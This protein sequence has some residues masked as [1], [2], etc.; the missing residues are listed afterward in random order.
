MIEN[1]MT[2]ICL[3]VFAV[4]LALTII[5]ILRWLNV[6]VNDRKK[7]L[8]VVGI[9]ASITLSLMILTLNWGRV[10]NVWNQF[11]GMVGS[12]EQATTGLITTCK[13]T[14]KV[15]LIGTIAAFAIL[16]ALAALLFILYGIY[17][18]FFTAFSFFCNNDGKKLQDDLKTKSNKIINMFNNPIFILIITGGILAVFCIIPLI[19]GIDSGSVAECWSQGIGIIGKFVG[20]KKGTFYEY[21]SLY[22][23]VFISVIGIGFAACHIIYEIIKKEFKSEEK[24]SF[25][26]EYSNSIGLITVGISLLV[27]IT[28]E[29]FTPPGSGNWLKFFGNALISFGSVI[30]IVALGIICL[31]TIRLLI[32]MKEDLIRR[33]AR[34]VFILV[35]GHCTVVLIRTL[36]MLYNVAISILKGK[37]SRDGDCKDAMDDIQEKITNYVIK[38]LD[39][40]IRNPNK[41]R[42]EQKLTIPYH[43]FKEQIT[44]K[45]VGDKLYE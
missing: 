1:M 29:K 33:G 43:F 36:T 45:Q 40:E 31:E 9:C 17:A 3:T 34:Y 28:S 16:L 25:W 39:G 22:I 12:N 32:D 10:A 2:Y 5:S 38:D 44:K 11:V 41:K 20:S 4:S 24:E 35:I 6:D 19:I 42:R 37:I 23:L 8:N 21:L 13:I 15:F 14:I 26:K 27:M 30:F 18:V 7:R